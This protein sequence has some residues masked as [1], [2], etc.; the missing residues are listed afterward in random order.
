MNWCLGKDHQSLLSHLGILSKTD[1]IS[2]THFYEVDF[3]LRGTLRG[4]NKRVY[5]LFDI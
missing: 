5:E 1:Y 3:I 2:C 4:L